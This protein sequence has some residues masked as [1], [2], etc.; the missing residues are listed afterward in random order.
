MPTSDSSPVVTRWYRRIGPGLVTACVVIG[1]GSLLASSKVGALHGASMGWLALLSIACLVVFTT[2]AAR[3]GV[4]ADESP[5]TLVADRIGR[6]AAILIGAA[7][8]FV[9]ATFQFGNNLGVVAAVQVLVAPADDAAANPVDDDED[10]SAKS[11]ENGDEEKPLALVPIVVVVLFNLFSLAFL[12]GLRDVYHLLERLMTAFVAVMLIAF[13]VNLAMAWPN[14]I[15]LLGGLVPTPA[16]LDALRQAFRSPKAPVELLALVATTFS[17]A[18]AYYQVYAVRHRG[19]TRADLATGLLDARVSGV[20]MGAITLVL[21]WTAAT[22]LHGSMSADEI[23]KAD[24]V[25]IASQLRPTFGS[26]GT[27][28][29]CAGLFSAAYSSFIVNSMIGGCIM[30]DGLG[31]PDSPSSPVAKRL[32]AGVMLI[33]MV[34]ALVMTTSGIKPVAAIVAAQ[35]TT[36]IVS[37]IMAGVLLWLANRRDVMG[38]DRIGRLHNVAGGLAFGLLVISAMLAMVHRVIPAVVNWWNAG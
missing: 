14:P 18:A 11:D 1:P 2:I 9:A 4:V 15:P 38:E 21:L 34:V 12:F 17:A 33:G 29:F 22:V 20:V 16:R 6:W 26:F 7:V 36:V 37:P 32:T 19:W 30:A 28:L 8:F 3:I 10:A 31:H 5:G 35:A 25:A 13:V 27:L 24:V 23:E